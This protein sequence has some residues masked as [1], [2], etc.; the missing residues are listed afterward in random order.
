MEHK[1]RILVVDDEKDICEMLKEL[2][3]EEGYIVETANSAKDALKTN[4]FQTDTAIID[5]KIGADD[6]IVLLK[7]IKEIRPALPVIMI[8]GHG[9]VE[10]AADAFKLGAYEFLEKPL[11][12]IKV[13]TTVRNSVEKYF[14]TNSQNERTLPIVHSAAMKDVFSQT[15][16][17]A[18]LK[19]SVMIL[20]ASG[21]GKELAAQS[22]HFDGSRKDKNFVIVNA[23]TLPANLAESELF[24]HKRGA[25]TG[26]EY[27]RTGAFEKADGGTLFIDEIADLSLEV[28]P[29]LLRVLETG[30]FTPLGAE[31]EI[32]VD[33]RVITATHKN[34][35]QMVVEG[36]FRADLFYRLSAFVIKIPPLSQRKEDILPIA[37]K[38]L[39]QASKEIGE[40]LEF[41]QS[42][43]NLLLSLEYK[44]NVRELKH[45]I[46][47]ACLF[48]NGKF[49]DEDSIKLA[50]N[51]NL[52]D[53]TGAT[54]A[55]FSMDY[56][57]ATEAFEL[58][59]FTNLLEKNGGN[60]TLSAAQIGMAQSNLSRKLK[61]LGIKR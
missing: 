24:G 56:K 28:Q 21:S 45:I 38:F 34:I 46:S 44:G 25:F 23:S 51:S 61:A 32:S 33:V 12:L 54:V 11:R 52:T 1:A 35:E 14:L 39:K 27:K 37:E 49:V 3:E 50:Q 16:R 29:K 30:K 17:L 19:M 57:T 22:L 47:R 15:A 10:L 59:Y 41:S 43:K 31:D 58:D 7:Q 13:R 9:S 42:A 60:I 2:L 4:L 18:P 48:A 55:Y 20:G 6:G 8:T 53:K 36:K 5:I 40:V 26:A